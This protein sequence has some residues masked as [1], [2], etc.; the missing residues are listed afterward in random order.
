VVLAVAGQEVSSL[1]G[2]YRRVW[3]L[4]NAGVEAPLTIYR[5]GRTFEARVASADR[6]RFL[7]GPR[8]H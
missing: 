1:A 5:D 7:K 2:F 8:L 6:A 4:G 3:S